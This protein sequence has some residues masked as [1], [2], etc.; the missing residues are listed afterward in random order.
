MKLFAKGSVLLSLG[1]SAMA[2]AQQPNWNA[3]NQPYYGS[4]GYGQVQRQVSQYPGNYPRVARF[5]DEENIPSPSDG[6]LPSNPEPIS[7]GQVSPLPVPAAAH[8]NP[9]PVYGGGPIHEYASGVPTPAYGS[10][11]YGSPAYGQPCDSGNCGSVSVGGVGD[12]GSCSSGTCGG[13]AIQYANYGNGIGGSWFAGVYGLIMGRTDSRNVNLG[14]SADAPATTVF[15]TG[16]AFQEYAGGG[17]VRFGR[18]ISPCWAFEVVYWGL[19]PDQ[20]RATTFNRDYSGM[21]SSSIGFDNLLYDNGTGANSVQTYYGTPTRAAL[22]YR[23][24]RSWEVQNVELNFLRIPV[25]QSG[26]V[27]YELLAGVRYLKLNDGFIWETDYANEMFGDDLANELCYHID[28]DNQL[29]GFQLGGR[30]DYYVKP[31]LSVHLGSKLGIYNNRVSH[32]QRIYGG[33]GNAYSS[34]SGQDYV[35]DERV[36][37]VAFLG[38]LFAGASYD[39]G[40]RWRLTGGYRAVSLC[41]VALSTDQIP[42]DR[43]FGTM[44]TMPVTNADSCLL[45]HGAYFGAEFVW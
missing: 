15:R 1:L 37:K 43:D 41:G 30:M 7:N 21:L 12:Y 22:A 23:L 8:A 9:A 6:Q 40:C 38:E 18:C 20:A 31:N 29:L 11:V 3:P 17:E 45:L 32:F 33:N 36:N 16:D 2:T 10:P 4:P 25:N 26:C 28:I 27:N 5:Q 34:T 19:F 44:P 13:G 42:R 35:I 39:I 14:Y 24:T